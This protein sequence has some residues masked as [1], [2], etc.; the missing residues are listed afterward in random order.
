MSV[1]LKK[2][3]LVKEVSTGFSWKY[4]FFGCLYVWA[5]QGFLKSCKHYF[6]TVITLSIYYWIQCFKYNTNCVKDM[7]LE[8]YEPVTLE[9][10]QYLMVK[11]NYLA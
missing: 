9:D 4:F 5:K 3:G 8:G 1:K 2:N 11:I 10:E 7:V 6:L